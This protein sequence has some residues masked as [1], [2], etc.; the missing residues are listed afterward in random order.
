MRTGT[1]MT[2][3]LLGAMPPAMAGGL[4]YNS[5]QSAEYIRTFDRGSALDNADI[6]YYN[7]A[8][9]PSLKPGWTIN[10]SD[11]MIS[12]KDA[13]DTLG[14]PVLGGKAYVSSNADLLVPDAYAA[15]RR[16]DWAA[17]FGLETLGDTGT[18]NWKH[19]LP[20]LNLAAM[21]QAGY[22]QTSV[23]GVIANDAYAA[24]AA[25]G[26]TPAQA[27]AAGTAAQLSSQYFQAASSFKTAST[28]IAFRAGGALQLSSDLA[29]AMALRYVD[30]QQDLTAS[31]DGYCT[32]DQY[33]HNL[34]DHVRTVA[35]VADKAHGLSAELGID[36]RT[37]PNVLLTLTWE[38]ATKLDYRT[39][40]KNGEG[41]GGQY[42]NGA[43]A[44]LDLPQVVRFGLGWQKT[45]ATR[46][47]LSLIAYREGRAD[48]GLLDDP[49]YG[50]NASS[51]YR[52]SYEEAVSVEHVLGPRWLV[53]FGLDYSQSGQR[54]GDTVDT[55]FTGGQGNVLS[56]G[57][58]FQYR[59]SERLK[60]NAGLAHSAFLHPY[61]VTDAG[62]AGIAAA[63]A[64]QNVPISP[65][66][67][68][69]KEALTFAIGLDYHF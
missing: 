6:V 50:I 18:H 27:Q 24:A 15:Y 29:L 55:S 53:S 36:L 30:A 31:A 9:T 32:Y 67:E 3:L 28:C 25:Q 40:I 59:A 1:L 5:N 65:A 17:F 14:N 33:N 37:D 13:V 63:F 45:P 68:Y 57:A 52:N 48:L 54:R 43:R 64:A 69:N 46:L 21:Q 22:N 16:N 60:L 26:A 39:T 12:R 34:T 56:E 8:G 61:R 7:M 62:D 49:T 38:M 4:V 10:L 66:K 58:G 23:S 41:G 2:A 19:G 20:S 51:A 42:V 35:D 47:S 44:R 11:Q